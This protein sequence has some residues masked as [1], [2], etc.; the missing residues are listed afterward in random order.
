MERIS[1]SDINS[2]FPRRS[3][4]NLAGK[5]SNPEGSKAKGRVASGIARY[6]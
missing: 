1:F 2:D 6:H 3:F 5:A 4:G